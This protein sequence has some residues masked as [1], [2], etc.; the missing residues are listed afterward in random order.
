MTDAIKPDATAQMLH[1]ARPVSRAEAHDIGQIIKDRTKVLKAHAEEQAAACLADFERKLATEFKFDQDEVWRKATEKVAE[2]VHEAQGVIAK[3]CKELGI[4]PEFAP[5]IS[6]TWHGRGQNMLASRRSEMRRVALSEI[7]AM[8]RAVLTKIERQGLELRT[9]VV[10]RSLLTAE[11]KLFLESFAPID[12]AMRE[13][14]FADVQ[15]KIEADN[16][17]RKQLPY[18]RPG[19]DL[20]GDI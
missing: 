5:T 15:R 18:N 14:D 20:G 17:G 11:A 16:A 3:R 9:Q 6:A 7:D 4:P 1:D 10:T 19:Y 13:L 12:E 2:I 8:R